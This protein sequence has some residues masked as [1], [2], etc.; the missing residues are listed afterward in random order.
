LEEAVHKEDFSE[1]AK[2]KNSIAEATS[3]DVVAQVMSD[4]KV[5]ISSLIS[6]SV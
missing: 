1:A 2:L 4:L 5:L 6:Y 3:K